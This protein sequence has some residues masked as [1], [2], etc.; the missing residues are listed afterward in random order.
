VL[1]EVFNQSATADG[2]SLRDEQFKLIRFDSTTEQFYDLASDPYENTNLL[3][4][5]L[6]ATAQA[7]Y[8][9]LKRNF[10]KYLALPNASLTRDPFPFPVH[11]NFDLA[12]G[13]FSVGF[14]YSQLRVGAIYTLWRTPD[15]ANPLAWTPVA[16][17][18]IGAV[19]TD[20]LG[21]SFAT[22][23]DDNAT[24]DRYFYQ[25]APSLW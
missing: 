12:G 10:Q 19:P 5:P 9:S 1:G 11:R 2:Q 16:T 17:S 14:E 6:T 7:H 8:Y 25:V 21:T 22:L 13:K 3:P 20:P 4:G 18:V 15:L 23:T 24:A